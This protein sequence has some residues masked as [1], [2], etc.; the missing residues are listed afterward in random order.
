[1]IVMGDSRRTRIR[2]AL[3]ERFA[4]LWLFHGS[5][6][7]VLFD[8]GVKGTIESA[9]IPALRELNIAPEA[10]EV[11]VVSHLDVDHSGDIGNVRP[12]LPKAT[13]IAHEGDAAAMSD[14]EVFSSQRGREFREGWG[15][16]EAPGAVEWMRNAFAP[17]AVD[18]ILQGEDTLTLDDG[19]VLEVWHVPG[20]TRGHLALYDVEMR[21]LAISDAILG[22]AVPLAD[23][24]PCFPPTYRHVETYLSTITRVREL[25]PET[26]LTAHYGDFFGPDIMA[27]LDESESFVH[28]LDQAV[29]NTL[30]SDGKTLAEIVHETNPVVASWP[31]EG[32][33]TALAFPVSGHLERMLAAHEI[34]RRESSRGWEWTL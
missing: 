33:Q 19:R 1:M 21:S 11:V 24:S 26:L 20:H 31:V 16:D 22:S 32:T 5:Q 34:Q 28:T 9:L 17:G 8:T 18:R 7:H 4:D 6:R 12:L 13:V 29:R 2:I 30:S 10:V 25:A 14:W 23:G 15:M 27:F 3:G